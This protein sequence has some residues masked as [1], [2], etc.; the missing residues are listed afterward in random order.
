MISSLRHKELAYQGEERESQ[1][2]APSAEAGAQIEGQLG[3][4]SSL[5]RA[6]AQA[7]TKLQ[8]AY[9]TIRGQHQEARGSA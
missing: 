7:A 3:P 1:G 5:L 9:I 4:W 2:A 6:T 8:F